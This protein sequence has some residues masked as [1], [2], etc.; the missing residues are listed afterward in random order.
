MPSHPQLELRVR[1]TIHVGEGD[2]EYVDR[3][4]QG[5]ATAYRGPARARRLSAVTPL[6]PW[7]GRPTIKRDDPARVRP[8]E[9]GQLDESRAPEARDGVGRRGDP[10]DDGA[11]SGPG[12]RPREREGQ[13]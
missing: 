7:P 6:R 10:D 4:L 5:H 13:V 2:G 8:A 3:C 9:G 11:P 12:G 1:A